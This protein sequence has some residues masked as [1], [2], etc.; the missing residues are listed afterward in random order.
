[1]SQVPIH[2]N[3]P[4]R[5]YLH[6]QLEKYTSELNFCCYHLSIGYLRDHDDDL[7]EDAHLP[8]EFV[9]AQATKIIWNMKFLI[10]FFFKFQSKLEIRECLLEQTPEPFISELQLFLVITQLL[11]WLLCV[12]NHWL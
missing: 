3:L 10:R 5:N 4:L 11:S 6:S 2:I 9:L 12:A 7:Q 1:M 8:N